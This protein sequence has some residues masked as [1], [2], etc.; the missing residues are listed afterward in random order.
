VAGEWQFAKRRLAKPELS[1]KKNG[2]KVDGRSEKELSG[3]GSM[4][5]MWLVKAKSLGWTRK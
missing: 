3:R 5:R 2:P 4:S 1:G